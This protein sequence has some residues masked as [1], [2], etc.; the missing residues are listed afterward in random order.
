MTPC[1]PISR[2]TPGDLMSLA[3]EAPDT[4]MHMA[5]VL[6]LDGRPRLA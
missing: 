5:A 1:A 3:I 4:P 6:V 2:L